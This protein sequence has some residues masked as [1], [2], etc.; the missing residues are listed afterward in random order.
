MHQDG[1]YRYA[2][3]YVRDPELAREMA[4]ETF[5]RFYRTLERFDETMPVKPWLFRIVANVCK[6]HIKKRKLERQLAAAPSDDA[7]DDHSRAPESERPDHAFS[8][9]QEL[10]RVQSALADL[11]EEYRL[12]LVLKCVEGLSYEEIHEITGLPVTTLKIRVVRAREA[13]RGLLAGEPAGEKGC[14]PE[15]RKVHG[16]G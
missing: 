7:S 14:K 9:A 1:V 3:S 8:R 2:L 11:R 6:D 4:Q 15:R 13:L 16:A 12:P 5:Y 10:R